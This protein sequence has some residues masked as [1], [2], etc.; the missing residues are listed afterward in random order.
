MN[1]AC[2]ILEEGKAL[3]ASDIDVTWLNGFGFRA[4]AAA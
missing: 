1:E 2:R 3:R 4:I